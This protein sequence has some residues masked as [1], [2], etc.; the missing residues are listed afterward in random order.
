MNDKS[1]FQ[2]NQLKQRIGTLTTFSIW[3]NPIMSICK[4]QEPIQELL[5]NVKAAKEDINDTDVFKWYM[6]FELN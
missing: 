6:H 5:K 3:N 4:M 2:F 1:I